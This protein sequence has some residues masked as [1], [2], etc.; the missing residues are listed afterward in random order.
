MDERYWVPSSG[1]CRFNCVGSW[2]T[3]KKTRSSWPYVIL[4]GSYVIFTDSAWPVSPVLTSSYSAV[5]DSPP[6]YPEV[7]LITPFTCW[8][9]AWIPQK[10][11]PATTAVCW[12]ELVAL[13]ASTAGGGTTPEAFPAPKATVP[14]T[15][16]KNSK[17][18]GAENLNTK[19]PRA[20][21]LACQPIRVPRR[22]KVSPKPWLS[23]TRLTP[24]CAHI[25]CRKGPAIAG[26]S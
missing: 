22:T 24:S 18:I 5:L 3:E 13:V 21:I 2:A 11:P 8:K 23:L 12:P 6:E 10:H 16:S 15:T 20:T 4:E 14:A 7:A 1:P 25:R 17:K 9:T 26:I 19:H